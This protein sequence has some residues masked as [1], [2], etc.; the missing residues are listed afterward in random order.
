MRRRKPPGILWMPGM[1]IATSATGMW[2]PR[3]DTILVVFSTKIGTEC[4]KNRVIPS[5]CAHWRGNPF[6]CDAKHHVGRRPTTFLIQTTIYRTVSNQESPMA[7]RR[8]PANQARIV[9]GVVLRAANQNIHDCR[10]QS[11]NCKLAAKL[12]FSVPSVHF[13]PVPHNG[14]HF[15]R[16]R[17]P[18]PV[19]LPLPPSR[20]FPAPGFH[21]V[22]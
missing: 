10:G 6:S 12:Q 20:D 5:Q 9:S 1:R 15:A 3:N 21:P 17:R 11:Y 19:S 7:Y 18:A 4:I 14:W 16:F 22:R 13:S 2:P 8:L